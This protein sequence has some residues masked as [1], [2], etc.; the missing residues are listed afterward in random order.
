[1]TYTQTPTPSVTATPT[2][3]AS[4]TP[5]ITP[6]G[7]VCP[8]LTPT[9][10]NNPTPTPTPTTE[11]CVCI[12]YTA[13]N[14]SLEIEAQVAWLN[15]VDGLYQAQVIDPCTG[16]DFCGCEGSVIILE[17]S[18]TINAVGPCTPPTPTPTS[19][20]TSTPTPTQTQTPTPTN[21]CACYGYFIVNN[22]PVQSMNVDWVDCDGYPTMNVVEP[23]NSLN[24]CACRYSV[25][26]TGGTP[27]V[28]EQGPCSTYELF[29]TNENYE[30]DL[31]ACTN[32]ACVRPYYVSVPVISIGQVIYNDPALT[33]PYDGEDKWIAVNPNCSGVWYIIQVDITGTVI[34]DY[35]SCA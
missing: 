18:A 23:F 31:D 33:S 13:T 32:K 25:T 19:T 9:A 4:Q 35:T 22:S 27:I 2:L 26:T 17:G 15:C 28:E 29:G 12:S 11:P 21:T 10:T 1:M 5:T 16:I 3:T 6:T 7:T 14:D 8:G 34:D 20:Q 30:T 24:V